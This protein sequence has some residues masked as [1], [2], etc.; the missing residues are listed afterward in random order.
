MVMKMINDISKIREKQG[1]ICDMDGVVYHGN[2][3]LPPAKKFV[4]WLNKE[5]KKYLFLTNSSER[6]PL[7]LRQKLQRMGLDVEESHFYTSALATAEFIKN[8]H[9]GA[10]VF[11][12]GEAGLH[13]ALYE[14]GI[15]MNDVCPDYVVVGETQN[16][17]YQNISKAVRLVMNG[18]K[19]IGTNPDVTG[20]AEGGTIIPACRAMISP[21]ELATGSSAYFLGKPNP[22]MMRTG[23]KLLGCHSADAAIIGDRMDTD[24]IAGIQSAVDTVLV[25]TGVSSMKTL[26]E[27]PY[28]P[29]YICGSVGDILED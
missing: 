15:S 6:S 13:N 16:Y 28:R 21:I 27:F 17:S 20:P 19:L 23:L 24:I 29:A 9:P 2:E 10:S 25:L 5:Q 3:L 1:F 7:E 12:I 8:Q 14:A 4:E 11:C 26:D 18:A 22:L